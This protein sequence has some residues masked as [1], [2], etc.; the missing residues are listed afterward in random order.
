MQTINNLRAG[1]QTGKLLNLT[2]RLFKNQFV[3][4]GIIYQHAAF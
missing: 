3:F 2:P 1:K 4:I